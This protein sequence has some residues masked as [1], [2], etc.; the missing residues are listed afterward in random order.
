MS[1]PRLI[2]W[3]DVEGVFRG[4]LDRAA[5]ASD[6]KL[7]VVE[8]GCGRKWALSADH[9][10]YSLIGID[11][12][13]EA[14]RLRIE[15][16]ADLDS[17]I[18]GS[19][20]DPDIFPDGTADA[21]YSSFVLEHVKGAELAIGNFER[22]LRPGGLLLL[23]FPDRSSCVGWFTRI[24]PF[25]VHVQYYR[26]VTRNPLAGTPGH[27]PYPTHFDKVLDRREF[28]LWAK[29]RSLDIVEECVFSTLPK[30][31]S[32]RVRCVLRIAKL[33]SQVSLGRL[34]YEWNNYAV[35]LQKRSEPLVRTLLPVSQSEEVVAG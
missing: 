20:C 27:N 35:V 34:A 3:D 32:L 26:K 29:R 12:D 15:E 22:W 2:P 11:L 4:H 14:L 16:Q 25:W 21:V 23:A 30:P 31:T 13:E 19:I 18:L 7:Q 9:R 17:A 10:P 8:A 28:R 24:T 1:D 6:R 5:A 33:V